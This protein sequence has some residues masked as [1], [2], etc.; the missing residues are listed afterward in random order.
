MTFL[1]IW[2]TCIIRTRNN[3]T[4]D[5]SGHAGPSEVTSEMMKLAGESGLE[6][7]TAVFQKINV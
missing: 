1:T 3:L 7:L 2:E 4:F 5:A 6:Q